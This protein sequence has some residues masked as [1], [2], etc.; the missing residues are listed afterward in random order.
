[1]NAST[2]SARISTVYDEH[3]PPYWL[4]SHPAMQRSLQVDSAHPD[5]LSRAD[6]ASYAQAWDLVGGVLWRGLVAALVE[7]RGVEEQHAER[8]VDAWEMW[9]WGKQP[10]FIVEAIAHA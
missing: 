7:Q 6:A 2:T 3:L 8:I 1:M 10:D 9:S 4:V 5:N